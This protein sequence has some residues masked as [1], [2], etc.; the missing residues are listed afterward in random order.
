MPALFRIHGGNHCKGR[1]D[2]SDFF[3]KRLEGSGNAGTTTGIIACEGKSDFEY[4]Q[5]NNLL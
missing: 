1:Q 2:V 5:S 3:G 4:G